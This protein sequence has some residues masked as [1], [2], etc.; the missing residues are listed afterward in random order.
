MEE[1]R[2]YFK[3]LHWLIQSPCSPYC[4]LRCHFIKKL[5]CK[6][7]SN[8]TQIATFNSPLSEIAI[9]SSSSVVNFILL[10][11]SHTTSSILSCKKL[12]NYPSLIAKGGSA[13]SLPSAGDRSN[14]IFGVLRS[15]HKEQGKFKDNV[16]KKNF[17][18]RWRIILSS[19][20]KKE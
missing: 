20:C 1:I 3:N 14:I 8:Q 6:E 9:V 19:N 5:T 18:W 16:I 17:L 13:C 4:S 7:F 11:L 15:N 2:P 12:N 10:S